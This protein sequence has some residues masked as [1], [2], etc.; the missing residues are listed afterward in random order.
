MM[1]G[2][3]GWRECKLLYK[4]SIDPTWLHNT[5]INYITYMII[6]KYFYYAWCQ[7]SVKPSAYMDGRGG[8]RVE[9][10][11]VNYSTRYL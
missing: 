2:G 1:G 11:S 10:G 5:Y 7:L 4:I 8:G 6:I 9:G 3:G